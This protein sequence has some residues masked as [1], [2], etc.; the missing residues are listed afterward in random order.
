MCKGRRAAQAG[1]RGGRRHLRLR[2]A[3]RRLPG[4]AQ[5]E[6]KAADDERV[7]RKSRY[8]ESL[9]AK[10]KER[11]REQDIIYE[12]RLLKEREKED[13]LYGDK[14][15]F[16]T[17]AYRKK[18]EEDRKWLEEEKIADA[19]EAADDVTKKGDLSGFYH[20]LMSA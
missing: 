8:I 7:E 20:N 11:E 16:V 9:I 5:A 12:R 2:R 14:E 17:A 10:Q 18:L 4:L 1:A 15:K 19:R 6:A 13:H 3:L